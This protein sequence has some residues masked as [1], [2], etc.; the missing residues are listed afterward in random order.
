MGLDVNLYVEANPT[1]EEL[2]KAEAFF[3]ARSRIGYVWSKDDP[4]VLVLSNDDDP[5]RVWVQTLH[6]FYGPY[7]ER[8]DWP[9]I[10]GAIRALQLAFPGAKVF[11]GSDGHNDGEECTPEM[12]AEIW[13]HWSGEEG[14]S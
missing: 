7:Y 13:E 9:A 5:P 12:L 2:A 6:R 8:G 4:G 3:I 14:E 1:P 11:Y 10:Y